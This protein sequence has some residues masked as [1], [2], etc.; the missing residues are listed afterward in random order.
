MYFF[1]PLATKGKNIHRGALLEEAV[2][3]SSVKITQLVKR[4]GI[5]RSTYYNHI[6]DPN[7]PLEQLAA[8]GR[9]LRHDFSEALP[10]LRQLQLEEEEVP[11][12]HPK[13]M[14]EAMTQRDYWRDKY[15]ALMERYHRLMEEARR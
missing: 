13:T 1:I 3:N 14:D 6:A 15:Y 4:L 11:Y 12:L 7:L 5:S 2:R 9:V 8:Y 10:Q